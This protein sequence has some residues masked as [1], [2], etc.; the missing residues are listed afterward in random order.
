MAAIGGGAKG[1][2][3]SQWE[4]PNRSGC[5]LDPFVSFVPAKS[6][7]LWSAPT[8]AILEA[9]RQSGASGSFVSC[10]EDPGR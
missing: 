1:T 8:P 9:I 10:R 3:Q 2:V 7:L 6:I 5:V 4:R